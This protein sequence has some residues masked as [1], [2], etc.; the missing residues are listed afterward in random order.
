MN[1]NEIEVYFRY[2]GEQEIRYK[3][4]E[5]EKIKD[6]CIDYASK[7]GIIFDCVHF[8]FQGNVLQLSDYDK[9]LNYFLSKL[10]G[11]QLHI[12]VREKDNIDDIIKNKKI[13]V[14]LIFE[15]VPEEIEFSLQTKM[16]EV[17]EFF[18]MRKTKNFF[19][20]DFEYRNTKI[21]Y[22]KN[23]EEIAN[24]YDKNKGKMEIIVKQKDI[25]IVPIIRAEQNIQKG[26]IIQAIPSIQSVPTFQL[27]HQDPM[28]Q[29]I[30]TTQTMDMD[31]TPIRPQIQINNS[32]IRPKSFCEKNKM[33]IIISSIV[34]LILILIIILAVKFS[35]P[36]N[37]NENNE[38]KNERCDE[39]NDSP[40]NKICSKCKEDFSLYK[41]ECFPFAFF[42]RYKVDYFYEKIQIFNPDKK[43]VLYAIETLNEF[44]E[45]ISE[46][47]FDDAQI[48]WVAFYLREKTPISL[49]HIFEN[50]TKLIDFEFNYKYMDNFY[51]TDMK[52]MFSGCDYLE[53]VS[54]EDF[55]GQ[56]V[57][58]ISF[59][60]SDCTFL[61][62]VF[63]QILK[64]II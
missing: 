54:F 47:Y 36:S 58:D 4:K 3:Y 30:P 24:I 7:K 20:L 39:Y 52:G 17:F 32:I 41:G 63:F 6:I 29:I 46:I 22:N 31:T 13:K 56:N 44:T 15:S 62:S 21:D 23:I 35:K 8:L 25:D 40:S 48:G 26:Q 42:A 53:E 55:K 57:T 51:I 16:K 19:S 2:E 59:L 45:P 12:L 5:N 9:P 11:N 34:S 61:A 64:G 50:V 28:M 49:S 27:I 14:I 38:T 1:I 10:S 37:D 18:A 43:D 33:S 60:F